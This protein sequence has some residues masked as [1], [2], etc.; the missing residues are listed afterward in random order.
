MGLKGRKQPIEE[1][2]KQITAQTGRLLSNETK[3]KISS[4]H[5]GKKKSL[6]HAKKISLAKTGLKQSAEHVANRVKKLIGKKRTP[7]QRLKFSGSNCH[8]WK[9]GITPINQKIRTSL[10]YKL[11]RTAVFERDKYTCVFCK[12]DNKDGKRT[13]LN[14][15]HIKPFSLFPELR[16]AI[17]NGRTLCVACHR[18][19]DTYGRKSGV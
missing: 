6:E 7:E 4:A 1:K 10:E 2:L 11:W 19:T 16:F 18:K 13:R 15:D 12:E 9:G 3:Q 8:L 17:D 14:A 5:K